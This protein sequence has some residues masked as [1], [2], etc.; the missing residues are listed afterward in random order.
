MT[1]R[2][3][4]HPRTNNLNHAELASVTGGDGI[5]GAIA[6]GG[7]SGTLMGVITPGPYMPL[8]GAINP[9]PT[10]PPVPR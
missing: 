6:S 3:P 9:W 5:G 10:P 7:A 2:N 8:S 4:H 1:K